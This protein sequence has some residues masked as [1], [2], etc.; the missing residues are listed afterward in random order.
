MIEITQAKPE[1][2]PGA[3][4]VF[5]QTWLST[6]PNEEFG[7]TVEDVKDRFQDR[8]TENGVAKMAKKIAEPRLNTLFLVAKDGEKIIGVCRALKNEEKNQLTAIY[9]LPDYQGKGVGQT[10]WQEVKKFFNPNKKITVEVVTYNQKAISFYQKL[11]FVDS[12]RRFVDEH[13]KMKSGAVLPEMEMVIG[14]K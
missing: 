9:V 4:Q 12:S 13:F 11:G 7:V 5:Y 6:Y 14:D 8:I 10:L 3:Q 2:A 1:D